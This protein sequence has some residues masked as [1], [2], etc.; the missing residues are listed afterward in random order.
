MKQTIRFFIFVVLIFFLVFLGSIVFFPPWLE[1]NNW[2]KTL[3]LLIIAGGLIFVVEELLLGG[4]SKFLE[5]LDFQERMV[6]SFGKKYQKISEQIDEF[7]RQEINKEKKSNKYIPN[8]FV[9]VSDIK[10]KLR[11][12][13][14]PYLFFEKIVEQTEANLNNAYVV[15]LLRTLD[16]PLGDYTKQHHPKKPKDKNSLKSEIDKYLDVIKEKEKFLNIFPDHDAGLKPEY[17]EKI[18]ENKIHKYEYIYSNLQFTGSYRWAISDLYEDLKTLQNKIFLIK[19]EA[20]HGKTNLLCDL[21]ENYLIKKDKTCLYFS[22]RQFNDIGENETI[23]EKII[24]ILFGTNKYTFDD[25]IS[26]VKFDKTKRTLFVLIDGLN[27]HRNLSVF[28]QKIEQFLQRCTFIDELKIILTCRSEYFDERFGNL[29]SLEK[30][31]VMDIDKRRFDERIPQVH[32]KFLISKYFDHFNIRINLDHVSEQIQQQFDED[33]LLLRIFCEAYDGKPQPD[34]LEDLYRLEIFHKYFKVK[35]ATIPDLKNT[36]EVVVTWAI[37]NQHFS[38]IPI[39]SF[40]SGVQLRLDDIAYENIIVRKDI[41]KKEDV[42]FGE[43]EVVNFVYDEFRDFLIASKILLIWDTEQESS[44]NLINTFSDPV[45]RISEGVT[46]YLCLWTIKNHNY[47]LLDY[48]SDFHWF[49]SKF[50]NS[51]FDTP[52]DYINEKEISLL[53]NFFLNGNYAV[54]ILRNLS[55]RNDTVK[56]SILNINI[57]FDIIYGLSEKEYFG[58][59]TKIFNTTDIYRDFDFRSIS[60]I[61]FLSI[62]IQEAIV[63]KSSNQGKIKNLLKFLAILVLVENKNFLKSHYSVNIHYLEEERFPALMV[64]RELREDVEFEVL[65]SALTDVIKNF[66]IKIVK[67]ELINLLEFLEGTYEI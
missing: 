19:S 48:I 36:V 49:E 61:S 63:N 44:K 59:L 18:P 52:E 16:Y 5:G 41:K 57:L 12:F 50:V 24:K 21:A 1:Q 30:M 22:T 11:Y 20:G 56:Y 58:Y 2:F 38:D 64:L 34:F 29:I 42:A 14:E 40:E 8:I 28:S 17:K 47:E 67:Q 54:N 4:L 66:K 62:K 15:N 23:E 35:Q 6:Y 10:E 37:N 7:T 46:K 32:R 26:F 65:R 55:Y 25:L 43:G 45:C 3:T 60:M 9:E 33:K 31:S 27:E 51:I 13:C 53:K 39:D